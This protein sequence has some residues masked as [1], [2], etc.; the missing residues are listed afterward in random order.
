MHILAKS[1]GKL[2]RNRKWGS[3][4]ITLA[5]AKAVLWPCGTRA[6]ERLAS[7]G[8][9]HRPAN[10][11]VCLRGTGKG[12]FGTDQGVGGGGERSEMV[13]RRSCRER[14]VWYTTR[15]GARLPQG[16]AVSLGHRQP[17][18]CPQ[19]GLQVLAHR[20]CPVSTC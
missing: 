16:P 2:W 5:L 9:G 1:H 6:L 17:G 15:G 20:R 7:G 13:H 3:D 12:G 4:V 19:R 18:L 11:E 8:L 14:C 10:D